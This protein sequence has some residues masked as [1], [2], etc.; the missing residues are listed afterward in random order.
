MIVL[1]L[2]FQFLTM[3]SSLIWVTFMSLFDSYMEIVLLTWQSQAQQDAIVDE[4]GIASN[5]D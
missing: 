3:S 5:T 1:W 4:G 2:L